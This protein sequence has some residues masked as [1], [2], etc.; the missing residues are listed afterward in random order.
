MATDFL[1]AVAETSQ[2]RKITLD[3]GTVLWRAQRGCNVSY[4]TGGFREWK[5]N[6]NYLY[7]PY[8]PD[9]MY[10]QKDK[11]SEGR[12]NPKGIPCLYLA[13]DKETAM[14]EVRAWKGSKVTVASFRTKT[15]LS[16]VDCTPPA[17][18]TTPPSRYPTDQEWAELYNWFEISRGFSE[19]ITL[20]DD[21]ADYAPTQVLAEL[22]RQ[23]GFDGIIYKSELGEGDNVALFD[24]ASATI[25]ECF[26]FSV[27]SIQYAFREVPLSEQRS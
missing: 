13:S 17:P 23:N 4:S 18:R 20:A 1:A 3:E 24:V 27:T 12:V 19:P 21:V 14:S 10:P 11:V 7:T 16:L 5:E 9:R 26:L 15:E 6:I 22:F 8:R 2:K 25:L